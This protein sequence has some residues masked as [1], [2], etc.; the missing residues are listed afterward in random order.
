MLQEIGSGGA[1]KLRSRAFKPIIGGDHQ[2]TVSFA[3]NDGERI[4]GMGQYQQETFDLKG[5]TLELAHRNSQ[6]S[7]PFLLFQ[8][9]VW[10]L[11]A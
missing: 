6:A 1:L 5:S 3:G 8:Q 2:L 11:M 7:V 10:F 4:Y 9:R